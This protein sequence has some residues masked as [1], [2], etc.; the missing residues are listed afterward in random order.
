MYS[1]HSNRVCRDTGSDFPIFQAPITLLSRSRWVGAVSSAGGMG[2]MET[3][4][5]DSITLQ[6]ES[7]TV[8]QSTNRPFGYHL[9]ADLLSERPDHEQ[10]VLPWLLRAEPRFVTIGLGRLWSR[11]QDCWRHVRPLKD[12]GAKI[13]YVVETI[14]EALRSEDAGVNGLILAGAEAGG[15]RGNHDLHIFS[16]L[17]Q[18][19]HRIDLPLVASGGI[20]DG[21]GMAGAFALGAE[22]VLMGTRFIASPECP[23]HGDYKQAISDAEKVVYVDFGQPD[24]KMLAIKNDYSE[25]VLRGDIKGDGKNPYIGDPRKIYLEGRTDLAMAG[26][27]ESAALFHDIKPVAEIINDTV[28][29]F[30][31]EMERLSYLT[32]PRPKAMQ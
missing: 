9:L 5:A 1:F 24:T 15:I 28:A 11:E 7:D 10:D 13:Y 18:V 32:L 30:W 22:G 12:V 6:A 31:R 2:L 4:M 20:V 3:A 23:V 26:V 21:Y 17:Q 14:E 19:R 25:A 8:R 27:G 29:I 16:L